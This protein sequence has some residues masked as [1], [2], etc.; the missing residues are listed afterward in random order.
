M[1]RLYPF[2]LIT[3]HLEV[4]LVMDELDGLLDQCGAFSQ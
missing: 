2:A 3:D 1:V 4:V